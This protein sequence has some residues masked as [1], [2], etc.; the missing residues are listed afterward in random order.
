[1]AKYQVEVSTGDK[2]YSG[3]YDHIYVTL[4]GTEGQSKKTELDGWGRDFVAGTSRTYTVKTPSSLGSLLLVRLDKEALI[5]LPENQWYCRS[6]RVSTPEGATELFPC[7]RWIS[8]G[9]RVEL[10]KAT[11][12]KVFEENHPLLEA[13]RK[14]EMTEKK[15]CFYFIVFKEGLPHCCQH[16]TTEELPLELQ[17]SAVRQAESDQSRTFIGLELK[18]KGL[19]G[20]Q[21]RWE[22]EEDMKNIFWFKKTAISEYVADHWK[23]DDFYGSQFLNGFNPMSIQRCQELPQNFPVT[24]EMVQPFLDE[25]HTLKTELKAGNIFIYDAKKFEGI[26][27]RTYNE[28]PLHVTPGL[29]LLYVNSQK[30]LKPIAIQLYQKPAE[31][32]PIFLPSDS[33]TDWLLAKMFINNAVI[34]EHQSV[35]HLMNTHLLVEVFTVAMLRH[36]PTVHPIYKLLIPHFRDTIPM[37]IKSRGFLFDAILSLTSLGK[38]GLVELMKRCLSDLTYSAL[39][40]PENISSR[41]L[42]SVPN[43][44]YRDDGLRLWAII[45][46]FVQ[47][48]VEHYYPSNTD[49]YKDSELQNWIS[50]IF[51]HGFL[52]NKASGIPQSF[53]S[54]QDLVKFLTMAIFTASAQHAAVNGGQFDY[55]SW[56]PNASLLLVSRPPS[57]KGQSSTQ[58][59]LDALPNV[60]DT[61]KFAA[62]AWVLSDTYSDATQLGTY[63]DERFDDPAVIHMIEAFQAELSF[64]EEAITERNKGLPVPYTYLLPSNVENSIAI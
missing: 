42:D 11:P 40:L 25:G 47:S 60:G 15:E 46:S 49:V 8:R 39:C 38:A 52:E 7:Y 12:T 33:E 13:H 44:Y 27:P 20:S 45:N 51:T 6:V 34:M 55:Q 43:F 62:I 17:R 50:D 64:L 56:I 63:T 10:R 28:R 54:V 24:D 37:N 57:T 21:D 26:S 48:V 5:L 41:G 59:L 58:T 29:C 4:I 1:M 36:L 16:E 22:K 31:D 32:N 30:Q 53:D 19:L 2:P 35:H 9:E 14:Q 61:A 18:I 23:E 3:T